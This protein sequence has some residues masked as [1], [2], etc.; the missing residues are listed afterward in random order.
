MVNGST[1]MVVLRFWVW[2]LCRFRRKK[3]KA[4]API[5]TITAI[6]AI[7]PIAAEEIPPP[8]LVSAAGVAVDEATLDVGDMVGGTVADTM[9]A[10]W[11]IPPA[12][13]ETTADECLAAADDDAVDA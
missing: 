13:L 11:V 2:F 8:E 7:P 6:A 1:D 5:T 4:P 10:D 3:K 12:G 9:V